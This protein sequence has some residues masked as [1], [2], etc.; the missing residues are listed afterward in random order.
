MAVT[1][2]AKRAYLAHSVFEAAHRDRCGHHREPDPLGHVE[3]D[4]VRPTRGGE[5]SVPSERNIAALN[6]LKRYRDRPV[7]PVPDLLRVLTARAAVRP[8]QP[9]G[10]LLPD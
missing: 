4:P 7:G 5:V 9:V 1:R 8:H 6:V 10:H 3:L 2:E